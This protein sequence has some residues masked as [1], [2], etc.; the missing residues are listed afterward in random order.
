MLARAARRA[1]RALARPADV[2]RA[3][4]C[5]LCSWLVLCT[6]TGVG[7]MASIFHMFYASALFDPAS[8]DSYSTAM[9]GNA[10]LDFVVDA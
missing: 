6:S 10:T 4:G 7:L 8:A 9:L 2:R 1:D 5:A 3:C